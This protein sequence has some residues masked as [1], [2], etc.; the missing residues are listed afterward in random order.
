MQQMLRKTK[1]IR[2]RRRTEELE[3]ST[4]ETETEVTGSNLEEIA[5]IEKLE[6]TQRNLDS[7][8]EYAQKPLTQTYLDVQSSKSIFQANQEDKVASLKKFAKN[9]LGQYSVTVCIMP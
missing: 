8:A 5:M 4:A 7:P 9:A 6:V 3:D 2:T 1:Q